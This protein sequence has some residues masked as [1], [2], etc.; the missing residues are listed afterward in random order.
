ML[1]ILQIYHNFVII[2]IIITVLSTQ[3]PGVEFV[4][5]LHRWCH[6]TQTYTMSDNRNTPVKNKKIG[7]VHV[8]SKLIKKTQQY[9]KIRLRDTFMRYYKPRSN[10]TLNKLWT[11]HLRGSTLTELRL[12]LSWVVIGDVFHWT[13]EQIGR[14]ILRLHSKTGVLETLI[15]EI[16]KHRNTMIQFGE[17]DLD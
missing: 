5:P 3:T 10:D 11:T 9:H 16:K 15:N 14:K 12:H 8:G 4:L 7:K 1:I 13:D 6:R 17:V 2:L